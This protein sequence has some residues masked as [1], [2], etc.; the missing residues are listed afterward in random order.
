MLSLGFLFLLNCL[1]LDPWAFHLVLPRPA[2]EGGE[3]GLVATRVSFARGLH[4]LGAVGHGPVASR[5]IPSVYEKQQKW[6]RNAWLQLLKM[7]YSTAPHSSRGCIS[8]FPQLL[9]S[10]GVLLLSEGSSRSWEAL[11]GL[12]QPGFEIACSGIAS[13]IQHKSFNSLLL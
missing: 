12:V 6:Q 8:A 1:Y 5:A 11:T 2:E 4:S 10:C 3:G 13:K 9:W 7:N